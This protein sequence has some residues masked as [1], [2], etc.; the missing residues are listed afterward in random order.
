MPWFAL[1]NDVGPLTITGKTLDGPS[2]SFTEFEAI[3]AFG[4]TS[5]GVE[6][7]M[8]SIMIPVSGCWQITGHFRD[9]ELTFTVWVPPIPQNQRPPDNQPEGSLPA[10]SEGPSSPANTVPVDGQVEAKRI[11]YTLSPEIPP[12]AKLANVSGTAILHAIIGGND[13]VPRKL[14]YVS[15]PQLLVRAA[16]DAVQLWRYGVDGGGLDIE[17]TIEVVFPSSDD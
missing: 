9:Q 17:T 5:T 12:E 3:D 14:Q 4:R 6:E 7:V 11:W 8:G 10:T 16:M 13:G 1:S 15:G 2:P